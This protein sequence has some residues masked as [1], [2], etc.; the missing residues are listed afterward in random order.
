M[1]LASSD[2]YRAGQDY[3]AEF[4]RDKIENMEGKSIKKTE[5][6]ETFKQWYS[7]NYGKTPPRGREITDFMDKR[8]GA[9]KKG[10]HNVRIIYEDEEDE[11]DFV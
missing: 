8:Y 10:W 5:L 3:L 1:V 2:Q 6:L 7:T 9:Y 4:A 11:E